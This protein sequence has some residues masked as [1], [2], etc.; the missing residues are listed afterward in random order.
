[1]L[2]FFDMNMRVALSE[3][4]QV[5]C[6]IYDKKHIS[7]RKVGVLKSVSDTKN[8]S[9]DIIRIGKVL[10]GVNMKGANIW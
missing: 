10:A 6:W 1:M 3:P 7:E 5:S 4:L 8:S 2:N 9:S